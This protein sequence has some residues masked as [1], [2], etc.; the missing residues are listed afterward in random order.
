VLAGII[1]EIEVQP[2][3]IVLKRYN[4]SVLTK[5]AFGES[6]WNISAKRTLN[7]SWIVQLPSIY[8]VIGQQEDRHHSFSQWLHGWFT[9]KSKCNQPGMFFPSSEAGPDVIFALMQGDEVAFAFIQCKIRNNAEFADAARSIDPDLVYS[10]SR[11]RMSNRQSADNHPAVG[12]AE[13]RGQCLEVLDNVPVFR[14]V[15]T[16]STAWPVAGRPRRILR[17]N[18]EDIEFALTEKQGLLELIPKEIGDALMR[19]KGAATSD[20]GS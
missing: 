8:G 5:A 17:G 11:N 1:D 6:T 14:I 2:T 13:E 9:L 15:I 7:G 4:P 12:K 18:V 19:L 3:G 16:Y 20:L 10:I